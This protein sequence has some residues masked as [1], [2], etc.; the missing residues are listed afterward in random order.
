M[1]NSFSLRRQLLVWLLVPILLFWVFGA[2]LAYT[3][4]LRFTNIANDRSLFDTTLTLAG[5]VK[6]VDGGVTV[7]LPRAAMNMLEL[8]PYDKVYYAVRGPKGN[9][10][11]GQA[12]LPTPPTEEGIVH[13][14][15]I[16][17]DAVF[18]GHPIR[19]AALYI[20]INNDAQNGLIRVQV[21]ET[22]V[23]RK[24]L[25]SEIVVSLVVSQFL[26]IGFAGVLVWYGIGRGLAPLQ[27]LHE[28]IESRSHV[29]LSPLGE[30]DAPREVRS[31][32]HAINDL[33]QRL[34][35]AMAVQQRFIADAAHQLRTPLAGLKT[36]TELALRQTDQGELRQA[37][38]HL[39]TNSERSIHLVNQLLSLARAEP[40]S[41]RVLAFEAVD[42]NALAREIT[43]E[44]VHHALNKGI[45]LG[46]ES[47]T[48][49]APIRGEAVLFR[50][51]LSNLIDNA[52]RYTQEGGRVT[53]TVQ[54]LQDSV[55]LSVEDNGLGIAV[56]DRER[57]FE[58]FYRA[59]GTGADGCGLGLAIVR[60]IASSH[61]AEVE[62]AD[63]NGVPGT[64]VRIKFPLLK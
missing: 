37:L 60:E 45:D 4:A 6:I 49:P 57:V 2:V 58:R 34:G 16:Y 28:E 54:A 11:S 18:K 14:Q 27:Q 9:L 8:D 38:K 63:R 36:Q 7:D 53:V 56:E 51:M 26:M 29:D 35:Q 47:E 33:L 20:P 19:I 62:L 64:L 39:L 44:W 12:E 30:E 22:L 13:N 59:L 32:I 1:R 31:L 43:K 61:G 46:Y 50:E 15:P 48:K 41:E 25:A 21:A 52:I 55:V 23:K 24:L 5:Q 40:G 17:Y 10:I 42:C 3:T